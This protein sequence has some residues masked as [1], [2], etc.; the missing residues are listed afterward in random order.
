MAEEV[1]D[2][3]WLQLNRSIRQEWQK[4]VLVKEVCEAFLILH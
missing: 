2:L 1:F 3:P 4:A